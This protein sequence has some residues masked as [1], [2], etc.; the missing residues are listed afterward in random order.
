MSERRE[1]VVL[2]L[3]RPGPHGGLAGARGAPGEDR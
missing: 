2:G 1:R 3:C